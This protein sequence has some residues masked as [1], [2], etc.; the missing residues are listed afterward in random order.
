MPGDVKTQD[1]LGMKDAHSSH[2]SQQTLDNSTP[3][4]RFP[5]QASVDARALAYFHNIGLSHHA[6]ETDVPYFDPEESEKQLG[7]FKMIM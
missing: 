5:N 3:P 7:R 6:Y 2:I 1:D 4:S